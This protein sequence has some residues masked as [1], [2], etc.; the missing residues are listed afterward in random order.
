MARSLFPRSW[1]SASTYN[2]WSSDRSLTFTPSRATC[3]GNLT[4]TLGTSPFKIVMPTT[5]NGTV[6]MYSHGYRISTPIPAALA[7]PLGL[8]A[9]TSY[10]KIS[11]PA[12]ASAFGT[13]VAYIGS[14]VAEVAPSPQVA[15]KLLAQGYALAGVGYSRQGWS[16]ASASGS[17]IAAE[18]LTCPSAAC[19]GATPSTRKRRPHTPAKA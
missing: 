10:Q 18:A 7:V 1:L 17:I 16:I 8:A 6:L 11:F 2:S 5:F 19:I 13:D 4:G 3:Q 15:E 14:G 9:S 12:F